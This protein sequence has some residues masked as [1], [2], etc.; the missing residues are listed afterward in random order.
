VE[1]II[2]NGGFKTTYATNVTSRCT[3]RSGRSPKWPSRPPSRSRPWC[4]RGSTPA[5]RPT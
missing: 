3:T 4:S 5:R 1:I 2:F